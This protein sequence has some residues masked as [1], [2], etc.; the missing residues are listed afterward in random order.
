MLALFISVITSYLFI[1][2]LQSHDYLF[3]KM[4]YIKR[5]ATAIMPRVINIGTIISFTVSI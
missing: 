5:N 4:M 1:A 2:G 3:Y